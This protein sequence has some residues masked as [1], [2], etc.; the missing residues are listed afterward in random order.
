MGRH[1]VQL[2]DI[3]IRIHIAEARTNRLIDEQQVGEFVPRALI[4]FQCMVILEPIRTNLHQCTIHRTTS[5][6]TVQP[7]DGPLSV[8]D[9]T[10]PVM[11]KE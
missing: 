11:P 5:R 3:A 1:L 7:N 2:M 10:V 4:V 6:T 9:M 8:C